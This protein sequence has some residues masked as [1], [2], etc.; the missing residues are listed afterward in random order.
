MGQKPEPAV[1]NQRVACVVTVSAIVNHVMVVS[2]HHENSKLAR[3]LPNDLSATSATFGP[4]AQ[5]LT[6]S[7]QPLPKWH[8]AYFSPDER[9]RGGGGGYLNR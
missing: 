2:Q 9:G 5:P 3:L 6:S 4:I 7:M 8:A 1:Q